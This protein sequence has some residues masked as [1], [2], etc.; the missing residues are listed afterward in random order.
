MDENRNGFFQID[1]KED[2]TYLKL[3]GSKGSGNPVDMKELEDYLNLHRISYEKMSLFSAVEANKDQTVRINREKTYEVNECMALFPSKDLQTLTARFYPPSAKGSKMTLEE[4]KGDFKAQSVKVDV[5]EAAVNS[6]F[7]NR[8]YCTDY[9]VAHGKP[10]VE[11]KDGFIEYRFDTDPLAKPKLN[12]DGSVDFHALSLVHACAKGQLLAVLHKEVPGQPGMNVYGDAIQPREVKRAVFKH[13]KDLIVSEDGTQLISGVDGHVNLIE[14]TV[15]VSSV[16]ELTNVDVSTGDVEFEG[17]VR[18]AGNVA[19]GYKLKATGDIEIRGIIEAAEVEAGGSISVAKGINGMTKGNVRAKG[20]VVTKYINS[21]KVSAGGNIQSELILNSE[22]AAGDRINVQG[23]KGFITGGHVR[24][25]NEIMAKT[26][27]SEMGVDTVI[28]VGIDP[29]LKAKFAKLQ[30]DNEE[31][32]KNIARMEPVLQAVA[33]RLQKGEK[34]P[35]EQIK[36]MQE[37]SVELKKQ[38]EQMAAN[39]RELGQLS[40]D[41]DTESAAQIVVTGQAHAGTKLIISESS[42]VLKTD[43]HY[44]R[45]RKESGDVKMLAL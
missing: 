12:E 36:K 10:V 3:Y 14:G 25:G 27:G 44:C 18:V 23:K 30:K 32:R 22:V 45:F 39:N 17:N 6:F 41:F 43:Y 9:E 4:I 2:S 1:V 29:E 7:N 11:G 13:G 20:N 35:P 33:Q 21:A 40:I 8:K 15:F 42:L 16:L 28:E 37:A 5:D 19:T 26:I 38:K 24:S 34:M 31:Y